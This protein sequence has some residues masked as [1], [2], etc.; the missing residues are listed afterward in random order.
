MSLLKIGATLGASVHDYK[1][2]DD[3]NTTASDTFVSPELGIQYDINK[4]NRLIATTRFINNKLSSGNGDYGMKVEG[5]QITT[6]WQHNFR[7]SRRFKPWFGVGLTSN[8]LSYKD[9]HTTDS[10]GYLMDYYPN[11]DETTF[12]ALFMASTDFVLDDN[13]QIGVNVDYEAAFSE[14]VSGFGASANIKYR[15]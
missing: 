4:I 10:D 2:K 7:V 8:I 1:I 6:A 5:Y 11:T 12:S 9:R 15:F 14:G 13:W 3:K